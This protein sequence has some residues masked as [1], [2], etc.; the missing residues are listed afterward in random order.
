[1]PIPVLG[2]ALRVGLPQ[3]DLGFR[4]HWLRLWDEVVSA[5]A[6][7]R[8]FPTSL[9]VIMGLMAAYREFLMTANRG[10]DRSARA[11]SVIFGG[12]G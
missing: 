6:G 11:P 10:T 9:Q 12:G 3:D 8:S 1:M 2:P 4:G 5:P 7:I